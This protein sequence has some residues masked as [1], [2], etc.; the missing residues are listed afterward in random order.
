MCN[1]LNICVILILLRYYT[2]ILEKNLSDLSFYFIKRE[3]ERERERARNKN[4]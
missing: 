2:L 1:F 4:N 3:R